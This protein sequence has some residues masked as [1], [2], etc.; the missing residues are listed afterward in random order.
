MVSSPSRL[1]IPSHT[2]IDDMDE[3][4]NPDGRG[5]VQV[6]NT[7]RPTE[8]ASL[9]DPTGDVYAALYQDGQYV[10]DRIM[11]FCG[12]EGCHRWKPDVCFDHC[13]QATARRGRHWWCKECRAQDRHAGR[14]H[15][16]PQDR[17]LRAKLGKSKNKRRK[18]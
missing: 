15:S 6:S 8:E 11:L 5:E 9:T 18:K 1:N 14:D 16:T 3:Y 2:P 7:G 10:D 4:P 12:H 17:A 13:A